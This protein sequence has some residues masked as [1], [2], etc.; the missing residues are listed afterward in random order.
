MKRHFLWRASP[1]IIRVVAMPLSLIMV[2][3]RALPAW[4]DSS[5]VASVPADTTQTLDKR[6]IAEVLLRVAT[7]NASP[8]SPG[9]L[10][11]GAC[12]DDGAMLYAF[13][14]AISALRQAADHET[15]LSE[16]EALITTM[17][18]LS[19]RREYPAH[20]MSLCI[21]WGVSSVLVEHLLRSEIP[22]SRLAELAKRNRRLR[23]AHFQNLAEA[24]EKETGRALPSVYE[25]N[26]TRAL[27]IDVVHTFID[28][29]GLVKEVRK[30]G[31]A[32]VF[33]HCRAQGT[34]RD[35][36]G[37]RRNLSGFCP[38]GLVWLLVRTH[39]SEDASVVLTDCGVGGAELRSLLSGAL[40]GK[41]RL[42][43]MLT[44][45]NAGGLRGPPSPSQPTPAPATFYIA[46]AS[47][48]MPDR[49]TPVD[50]LLGLIGM[51][52]ADD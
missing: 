32:I 24:I 7:T 44:S 19:L 42:T 8:Q 37:V 31:P 49:P 2:L 6:A 35:L 23:R 27:C 3:A 4:A 22:H 50:E 45:R 9:D 12:S 18:G 47:R 36:F 14:R 52:P 16:V 17:E 34:W 29:A 30:H 40:G 21:S 51:V 41:V 33:Q 25:A 5:E 43:E 1:W 38:E 28:D 39:M 48:Y 26:A 15:M 10:S 46:T 20:V 13:P 11:E